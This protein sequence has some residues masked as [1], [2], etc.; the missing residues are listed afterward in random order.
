MKN[1]MIAVDDTKGTANAFS[2][3][4]DVCACMRPENVVLVFVE[5][6]EGRSLM[7]EMLGEAEISTLKDVL[8]GTDYKEAL[9]RKA[10]KVLDHYR[11]A[12][13]Q[14]GV[15]SVRGVIRT[16]HPADEILAAAKEEKADMI[17]IGSR[18]KRTTHL[19][20][21]SVS[22]EVANRSEVPVLLVK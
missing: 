8:H 15:T 16:G 11:K 6:F 14:K 19:F 9:D 20:M 17:V 3:C 21:G 12:L 22:R 18:G 1:I 5:K 10:R 13:E 7:D 4:S 2:V